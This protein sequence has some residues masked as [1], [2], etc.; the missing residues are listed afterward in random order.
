MKNVPETIYLQVGDDEDDFNEAQLCGEITWCCDKIN[1]T[2]IEYVLKG[3][4]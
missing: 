4:D 2:D 1:D 3:S